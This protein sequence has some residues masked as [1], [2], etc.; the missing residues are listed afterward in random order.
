M[1]TRDTV[2]GGCEKPQPITDEDAQSHN[3]TFFSQR[4]LLAFMGCFQGI[5]LE[6]NRSN[7]S[8]AIV[9][10][11]NATDSSINITEPT[12]PA[13]ETAEFYW[14][15]TEQAGLLS[16][17]FYGYFMTQVPSGILANKFG[18]KN[19]MFVGM[20]IGSISSLL[21]PIG[22]RTSIYMA[23]VLRVLLGVSQAVYFPASQAMWGRWAPPLERTK[24]TAICYSGTMFGGIATFAISG[25]LCVYGF[26]NGWGSIFYITG[27]I[28]VF[29]CLLWYYTVASTPAQHPRIS[30]AER[31][32]IINSIGETEQK[33]RTPWKAMM[34]S[35]ASWAF[36][37]GHGCYNWI[38]YT[39][40]TNIPIYLKEVLNFGITENGLLSSVA[41]AS[42][43]V[44]GMVTGQLAD[45]LRSRKYLTTTV[46]RRIF[47]IISFVGTGACLIGAGFVDVAHRYTAIALITIGLWFLGMSSA[48]FIVNAVDFAP[49]HAG[50]LFGISNSVATIPGIISP[51][52]AGAITPNKTQ[53]EWRNMLY[54]CGGFCVLGMVVFGSLAQGELQPWAVGQVEILVEEGQEVKVA[55]GKTSD[56][57]NGGPDLETADISTQL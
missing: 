11:V 1:D 12:E 9:C 50:V 21:L 55:S 13:P 45:Y 18:G 5:I 44:S 46:T 4:M 20:L 16:S 31:N 22:A 48:G 38:A 51:L 36:I 42:Q 56:G 8:V 32:Y 43:T 25:L 26:D 41:F 40:T 28:S 35:P 47:Q 7:L 14:S 15:K 54:V 30:K 37:T 52:L 53:E 29:W 17:Y 3:S 19:V 34:T 39:L 33:H 6:A 2:N 57:Q 27:A 24:L 23:Y 10:M 49:R